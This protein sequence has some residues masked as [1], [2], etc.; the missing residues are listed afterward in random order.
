MIFSKSF[1]ASVRPSPPEIRTSRTCGVRRRY[2]SWASCSR[3]LQFLSSARAKAVL[4]WEGR[5]PLDRALA[6]TVAWYRTFLGGR[7]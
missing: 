3:E 1:G 7:P 4:G 5:H 6:E 2:S